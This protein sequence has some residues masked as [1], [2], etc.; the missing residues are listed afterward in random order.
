MKLM[1]KD[2]K[3]IPSNEFVIVEQ[4]QYK[5]KRRK[6]PGKPLEVMLTGKMQYIVYQLGTPGVLDDEAFYKDFFYTL[7]EAQKEY[8]DVE[9][10]KWADVPKISTI[11]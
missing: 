3:S 7:E 10:V 9:V 1:P 8:P 2:N 5:A 4:P 6:Q 11:H